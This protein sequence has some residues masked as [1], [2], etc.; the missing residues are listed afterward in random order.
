M[1][2]ITIRIKLLLLSVAMLSIPY[3]GFQYLRET[4][5]YLQS[6]LEDSLLAVGGA[7]AVSLQNQSALF[8]DAPD[9]SRAGYP[10]FVHTQNYP[11]HIDGYIEDWAEYLEWFDRFEYVGVPTDARRQ[12]PAFDLII[13]EHEQYLNLLVM[14]TDESYVYQQAQSSAPESADTVE[15]II[16]GANEVTRSVFI[17][18]AGPGPVTGYTVTENWDFSATRHP[19][20]NIVGEWRETASGY[21]VEI[22]VPMNFV[23]NGLGVRVHDTDAGVEGSLI[24][25]SIAESAKL[26]PNTLLRTSA[27][28]QQTLERVGL[29]KGRRVWVINRTGQVLASGGSLTSESKRGAIN[30]LYTW[31]LPA[32]NNSFEDELSSASR[33]RGDEVLHALGGRPSTRW[34]SSPDE[35]AVIVSA[36]HPVRSG[37]ELVG[38]IVVEE[39]TNSIQTVQR[40]AMA[41]LFNKSIIVFVGVSLF[42]LVFASRLSY[43]ITR[44]RDESERAIDEHGR[45]R[46]T[47]PSSSASDEIGDL[48]RSY[49]AMLNRL[50]EYNAYLESMA[51]KLSHELRTPLAVVSSS[52]ENLAALDLEPDHERYLARAREGMTRLHNLVSRL[53]EASRLEQSVA[54]VE[55]VELDVSSLL[56]GCVDGYRNAYPDYEFDLSEPQTPCSVIGSGDLIAQLLDKII[57]NATAF[58]DIHDP[59]GVTLSCYSEHFELAIK[60]RGGT[61]PDAMQEQIFNSMVSVRGE[62]SGAHLGLGL[63][64]ARLIVEIHRGRI[65]ATNLDDGSGV[66]FTIRLPRG[67]SPVK[68]T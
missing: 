45:V 53:S 49:A 67:A 30:F 16:H 31:I 64:I 21:V 2:R 36:A 6:S 20:T 42:L 17:G 61:L 56:R 13:G 37:N 12:K 43:R 48:T 57:E 22:R 55:L 44:L 5:R 32:A 66:E 9:D 3:V 35:R 1:P 23:S 8:R 38:A 15:L 40:D 68:P 11:T 24:V 19:V 18:T 54:N 7:L 10:L 25:S 47:I 62:R 34:R 26:R 46:G 4:E 59:I 27:Q 33:L 51:S 14:V 63:H 29:K 39:T 65:W 58:S 60:N 52:F 28:L 41:A 50:T